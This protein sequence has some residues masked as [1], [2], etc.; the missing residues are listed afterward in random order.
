MRTEEQRNKKDCLYHTKLGIWR[1]F[2][3]QGN[4]SPKRGLLSSYHREEVPS[5]LATHSMRMRQVSHDTCGHLLRQEVIF[6]ALVDQ[7]Q[8]QRPHEEGASAHT[9]HPPGLRAC[10][11]LAHFPCCPRQRDLCTHTPWISPP[12][13]T[14]THILIHTHGCRNYSHIHQT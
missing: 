1:G 6:L 2:Q 14:H 3:G 9:R 4:V 7:I 8:H 13:H 12:I 10:P 5:R 11:C